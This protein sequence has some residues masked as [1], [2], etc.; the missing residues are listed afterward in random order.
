MWLM[1]NGRDFM[2]LLHDD[3]LAQVPRG[4]AI[5]VIFHDIKLEVHMVVN[6]DLTKLWDCSE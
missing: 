1:A 5:N 4:S 2:V 6:K 3:N